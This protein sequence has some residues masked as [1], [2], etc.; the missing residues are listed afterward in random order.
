MKNIYYFLLFCFCVLTSSVYAQD[1][2][3]VGFATQNGGTT[4][5]NS[6]TSIIDV[7][8]AAE[9][10]EA[11]GTKKNGVLLRELFALTGQS[12]TV[13]RLFLSKNVLI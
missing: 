10:A 12:I 9:L 8:N 7:H 13:E 1:F 6:A 4:G 11:I 5:G 3:C 2:S